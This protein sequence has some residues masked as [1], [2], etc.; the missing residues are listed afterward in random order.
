G[1]RDDPLRESSP[2]FCDDDGR[3]SGGSVDVAGFALLSL[4][5][6]FAVAGAANNRA[7]RRSVTSTTMLRHHTPSTNS[8]PCVKIH[9]CSPLHRA[10]WLPMYPL[11]M[12]T[13]ATKMGGTSSEASSFPN[14]GAE[15]FDTYP[16]LRQARRKLGHSIPIYFTPERAQTAV[17]HA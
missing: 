1:E 17:K 14:D 11:A 13:E 15:V 2:P 4:L 8:T 10:S 9:V 3:P 12:I 5:A 16:P 7:I 6:G